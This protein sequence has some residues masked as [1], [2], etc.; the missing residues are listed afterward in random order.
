M[1][2]LSRKVGEGFSIIT[3]NG[4]R[5]KVVYLR[6]K[7]WTIAAIGIAAPK[8]YKILREEIEEN[9]DG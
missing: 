8:N 9:E 7:S 1:L 3:P 4:E 5:I 6:Q 2:V